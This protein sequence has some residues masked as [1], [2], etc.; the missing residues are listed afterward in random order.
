MPLLMHHLQGAESAFQV[1]Q[2]AASLPLL[3]TRAPQPRAQG[4]TFASSPSH[5][6]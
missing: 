6:Q 1:L 5:T 3:S 4:L 2:A